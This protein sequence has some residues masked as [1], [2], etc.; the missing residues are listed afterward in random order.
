MKIYIDR[1]FACG[2]FGLLFL[3]AIFHMIG[4]SRLTDPL[5]MG[6][7]LT[8][9]TCLSLGFFAFY[10]WADKREDKLL[11]LLLAFVPQILSLGL[12]NLDSYNPRAS[13]FQTSSIPTTIFFFS[14]ITLLF[15]MEKKILSKKMKPFVGPILFLSCLFFTYAFIGKKFYLLGLTEQKMGVGLSIYT[16]VCFYLIALAVLIRHTKVINLYQLKI[17][18]QP[19]LGM[20][21]VVLYGTTNYLLT[22]CE[23]KGVHGIS[24]LIQLT[25]ISL[26]YWFFFHPFH[27]LKDKFITICSWS[28]Q[29]KGGDENWQETEELFSSLGLTVTHG[30]S[31]E[32]F[33]KIRSRHKR[34]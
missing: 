3:N 14:S 26:C 4:F 33:Q 31:E 15:L 11:L 28:R 19:I 34:T 2:I 16:L 32:H 17:G 7:V 9:Y 21:T 10:F 5:S 22:F 12:H 23:S 13:F 30:I 8:V 29:I 18:Y 6:S 27:A 20:I 1:A 25:F 24:L